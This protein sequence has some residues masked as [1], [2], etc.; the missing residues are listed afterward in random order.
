MACVTLWGSTFKDSVTLQQSAKVD[1]TKSNSR[2]CFFEHEV[3]IRVW[4]YFEDLAYSETK[5]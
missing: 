4:L 2:L 1:P 3:I 5:Q